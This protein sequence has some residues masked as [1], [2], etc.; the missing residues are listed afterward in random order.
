MNYNQLVCQTFGPTGI[1]D[2]KSLLLPSSVLGH[3]DGS[4]S[5]NYRINQ[6]FPKKEEITG[7]I[8][9][10]FSLKYYESEI[11]RAKFPTK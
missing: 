2:S 7:I 8:T 9:M 6:M 10:T 1:Q 11:R 3:R 5:T 4:G